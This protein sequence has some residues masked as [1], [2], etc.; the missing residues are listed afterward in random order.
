M[1]LLKNCKKYQTKNTTRSPRGQTPLKTPLIMVKKVK[2]V[3]NFLNPQL[4]IFRRQ[5][6]TINAINIKSKAVLGPKKQARII[7][8]WP[9]LTF[10]RPSRGA[11]PQGMAWSLTRRLLPNVEMF[12][13]PWKVGGLDRPTIPGI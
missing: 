7:L 11:A 9:P 5:R 1:K 3:G 10:P 4:L 8:Q 13:D 2:N 6:K 12:W